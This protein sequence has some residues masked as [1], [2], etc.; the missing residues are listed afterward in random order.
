LI[1]EVDQRT[2]VQNQIRA[3]IDEILQF[4]RNERQTISRVSFLLE[5]MKTVL[6]SNLIQT[7]MGSNVSETKKVDEIYPE[8]KRKLTESLI[9]MIKDD[10]DFT[11]RPRDVGLANT[12][13]RHWDDYSVYFKNDP[14][15]VEWILYAYIRAL[16]S[17]RDENPGYLEGMKVED[18]YKPSRKYERQEN[19]PILYSRLIDILDGFENHIE[20]LGKENMSDEAT[21]LKRE[22]LEEFEATLCNPAMS[23]YILGADFTGQP[24]KR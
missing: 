10:C 23:K 18:G 1:I 4:T 5:D 11:K 22:S 24:C 3:D 8:Y 2:R 20:I 13:V 12:V 6:E 14:K 9:I 7:Q 19:E 17:L 15:Q 16:Q 21:R